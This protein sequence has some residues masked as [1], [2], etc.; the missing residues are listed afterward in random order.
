MSEVQVQVPAD[1]N[2]VYVPIMYDPARKKKRRARRSRR[3]D[4]APVVVY[5]PARRRRRRA[6]RA[7]PI[8]GMTGRTMI[9]AAIDG[10]AFSWI[11]DRIPVQGQ[12]GP[13]S[14]QDAVAIGGAFAYEKFVMKRS[15]V[16]GLVAGAV[17]FAVRKFFRGG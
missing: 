2:V 4:P 12:L 5:D 16:A 15:A 1:R 8:R 14:V 17:A 7:D 11:A 6:R 9:D 13:I 3:A 10:V